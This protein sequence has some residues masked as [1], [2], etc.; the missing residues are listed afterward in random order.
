MA[1]DHE[2]T[3]LV[4]AAQSDP[5]AADALI[6]N[7]MGFIR[8]EVSKHLKRIPIE[9]RDDELGI[10]M[11]AFHEAVLSYDRV[12]GSFMAYAAAAIRNRLIDYHRR[13]KRHRDV[14]SADAPIDESGRTVLD[15]I[16]SG[17]DEIENRTAR[18]AAREEIMEYA[19]A[20][21]GFGISLTEVADSS[22]KQSRTL[23]ACHS[24]LAF[25]RE[26]PHL[27]DALV[28]SGRLPIAEISLGSGVDRKTIE[29]HRKYMIAIAVAYTNGYEIIRGH[30]CRMIPQKEAVTL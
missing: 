16:D 21:K 1:S 3:R 6:R 27:L 10:A 7:Y 9:G 19:A 20:L 15:I 12:R 18:H 4:Q 23:E 8:V 13:E 30:L 29:R 24:A 11:L 28:R 14:V 26:N 22:P 25:M 17:D 2:L 5:D